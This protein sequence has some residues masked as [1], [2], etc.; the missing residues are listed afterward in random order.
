V[1]IACLPAAAPPNWFATSVE[2]DFLSKK[3]ALFALTGFPIV[4]F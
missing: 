3:V 4:D 2:V 1:T